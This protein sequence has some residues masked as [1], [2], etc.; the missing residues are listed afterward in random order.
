MQIGHH[1]HCKDQYLIYHLFFPFY[2]SRTSSN[3]LQF[4]TI[5]IILYRFDF[6]YTSILRF[7]NNSYNILENIVLL[8]NFTECTYKSFVLCFSGFFINL[9]VPPKDLTIT[10]YPQQI[11]R[12]GIL[13]S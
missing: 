8:T 2:N 3:L 10:F 13:L 12:V 9:V 6:F 5:K 1:I 11:S 4:Q 7:N